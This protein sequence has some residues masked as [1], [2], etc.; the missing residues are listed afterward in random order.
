M[1]ATVSSHGAVE[2]PPA[3]AGSARRRT[4]FRGWALLN[5]VP[6]VLVFASL[7]VT[8]VVTARHTQ[9]LSP[10]DEWVYY[11]Y[12]LKI[13]SQG[14]V[15]QGES[16]GKGALE[17]MS[18]YGDFFG[19]RGDPCG[20]SYSD[21]RSYPQDGKTTADIYTP[22]YFGFTWAVGEAIHLVTGVKFLT[23]A[24]LSGFFWLSGG[25][26]I[27]YMLMRRFGIPKLVTLGVGLT[28]IAAPSTL[29]SS[30]YISTDAPTLVAGGA[31]LLFA[32]RAIDR[33]R[34]VWWLLPVAAVSIWLKVTTIFGVGLAVLVLLIYALWRRK[35]DP[36][37]RDHRR[38]LVLLATATAVTAVAA[39]IVWLGIHT[40]IAIG[41]GPSQGLAA[42]FSWRALLDLGTIFISPGPLMSGGWNAG[43]GLPNLLMLPTSWLPTAGIIG[44]LFMATRSLAVKSFGIATAIAAI[45]FAPALFFAMNV[46]LGSVFPV[47]PRYGIS[48]I[49]AFMVTVGLI[50]RN[51]LATW[52]LVVYGAVCVVAV[53]VAALLVR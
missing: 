20:S 18:C 33:K 41:P 51:R 15:R 49:P 28:V 25:V 12:T 43:Y 9:A 32:F 35:D 24:R 11:D 21:V 17:Q 3:D 31:A 5:W 2:T 30:T 50:V 16:I 45:A 19:Q 53:V 7:L 26:I 34:G 8:G 4:G 47:I 42:P 1:S 40:A 48:L 36:L 10:L 52:G 6:I 46:V 22:L 13:P 37:D 38:R 29:W 14:I 23:A 39:E 44:V 27:L